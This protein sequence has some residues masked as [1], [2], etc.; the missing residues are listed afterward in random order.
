MEAASTAISPLGFGLDLMVH[1]LLMRMR[2]GARRGV[3]V[4]TRGRPELEIGWGCA[5]RSEVV[6]RLRENYGG[7]SESD[8]T[9]KKGERGQPRPRLPYL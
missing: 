8:G 3:V 2:R 9:T 7:G 6:A 5:R 4:L 1:R